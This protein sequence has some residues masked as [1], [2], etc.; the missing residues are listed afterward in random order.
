LR[1]AATPTSPMPR[2]HTPDFMGPSLP[3]RAAF[4]LALVLG[5]PGCAP[6][7]EHWTC[8]W[9]SSVARPLVDRDAVADEGGALP[10]SVCASTCGPPVASCRV[11]MLD[12]G[13]PAA[14]CPVCSF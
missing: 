10:A 14:M 12:A 6:Q 9:D 5:G 8:D 13:H 2:F 11:T 1:P 3:H 4:G 7:L